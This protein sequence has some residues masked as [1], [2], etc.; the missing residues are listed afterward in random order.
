MAKQGATGPLSEIK[1]VD[2][3][4]YYAGPLTGMLLADQ[5]A[6]VIRV[7]KPWLVK[8]SPV[9]SFECLTGTRR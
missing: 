9:N 7:L 3:G 5:G 6:E 2:F 1:V 4:H 8:N